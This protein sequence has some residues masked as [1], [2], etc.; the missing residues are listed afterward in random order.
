MARIGIGLRGGASSSP[1]FVVV[2]VIV[3]P[4]AVVELGSRIGV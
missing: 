2:V 3:V 1:A 4:V